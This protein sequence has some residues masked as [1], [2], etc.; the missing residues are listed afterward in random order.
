MSSIINTRPCKLSKIND[1]GT[2]MR[3]DRGGYGW[4]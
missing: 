4:K 2:G 3:L 1:Y